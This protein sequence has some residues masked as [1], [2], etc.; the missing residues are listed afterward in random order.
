MDA[1]ED[2]LV[3]RHRRLDFAQ[4]H[5]VGSAIGRANGRQHVALGSGKEILEDRRY[6]AE[7]ILFDKLGLRQWDGRNMQRETSNE[8]Q[9]GRQ[10]QEVACPARGAARLRDSQSVG[11]GLCPHAGRP[12]L[13]GAGDVE[14]CEG[15]RAGQA[16]RQGHARGS[17]GQCAR[18]RRGGGRA[19]DRRS[20]EGLRRFARRGGRDDPAGGGRRPGR[21]LDRGRDRQQGQAAVRY[22][23]GCRSRGRG[24]EGRSRAAVRLRA[25]RPRRRMPARFSPTSTT[26]SS[27]CRPSRRP[28]PMC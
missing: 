15:R 19:G 11:R 25:D 12:R 4:L 21:R 2:F 24:G 18:D 27:A 28:A 5:D 10:G 14:R 20:R 8:R 26:S 16:R 3:L 9:S 1:D 22:R 6:C 7:R 17:A 23:C 13:R